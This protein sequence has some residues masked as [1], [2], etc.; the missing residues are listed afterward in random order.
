MNIQQCNICDLLV[1]LLETYLIYAGTISLKMQNIPGFK[2]KIKEIDLKHCEFL[3]ATVAEYKTVHIVGLRSIL[4]DNGVI[5]RKYKPAIRYFMVSENYYT[6]LYCTEGII[7]QVTFVH[8]PQ[9]KGKIEHSRTAQPSKYRNAQY[10]YKVFLPTPSQ[11]AEN[12]KEVSEVEEKPFTSSLIINVCPEACCKKRVGA[13]VQRDC[14]Y[15]I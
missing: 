10:M 4:Q 13:G 7:L 14:E 5:F 2:K 9:N 1:Q 6:V 3:P 15:F 8:L 12:M 11:T